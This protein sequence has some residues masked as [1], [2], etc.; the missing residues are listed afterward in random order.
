[1]FEHDLGMLCTIYFRETECKT[2]CCA[3]GVR[4][5]RLTPLC[6]AVG[7]VAPRAQFDAELPACCTS[8]WPLLTPVKPHTC[9]SSFRAPGWATKWRLN[10][11]GRSGALVREPAERWQAV[12]AGAALSSRCQHQKPQDS[13]ITQ[14]STLA[15]RLC[16][17]A[18]YGTCYLNALRKG[19]RH[20][21]GQKITA[22]CKL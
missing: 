3:A 16:V 5:H 10:T 19:M 14:W 7:H 17:A 4:T 1:M 20:A 12:E 6:I 8:L 13:T 2:I 11:T 22:S 21:P 9:G 15:C 18:Q